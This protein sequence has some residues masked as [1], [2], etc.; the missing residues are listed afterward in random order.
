MKRNLWKLKNGSGEGKNLA[1]K[2][3]LNPI[4]ADI[5]LNRGVKE[6]EFHSF[7]F[8]SFDFLH[9]P[10]LLPDIKKAQKRIS[11]AVQN[12]EKVMVL[13]DYDVDG[14][15][16]LAIFNEFARK[17]PGV[18]SFYIPH[19]VKEGYGLSCRVIKQ[20]KKEK[21]DLIITFDC[22]VNSHKEVEHANSLG[23]DVVIVDHHLP[24]AKLPEAA[25]LV[26]PKRD[27][28][29]YPFSDLTAG[30]L[31]FKLL[32]VLEGKDCYHALDLVALSIVCDV[33]PLLGEN[34]ILLKEG[35][36]ILRKSKRTAIK[37]LCRAARVNQENLT[38]FHI[39][40]ILGPRV[41]A[42]GRIAHAEDAF[43]L[44][45]SENPEESYQMALKLN[46]YNDLRKGIERQIF[47][48]AEQKI[49]NCFAG[50]HALV[51]GKSGWHPGVLGVVAS[52][53]KDKYRRPSF[54]VSFDK[55][56]GKGSGRSVEGVH[57]INMLDKCSDFLTVYGGHKKAVGMELEEGKL[58]TFRESINL[59][60]QENIGPKGFLPVLDIDVKLNFCQI[61]TDFIN[62]LEMLYPYGEANPKPI[63]LAENIRKKKDIQ[64]GRLGYSVWL[65]DRN[66]VLEAVTYNKDLV[67]II[68][69]AKKL[70]IVFSLEKDNYHN[71]PRL[72]L[73][74]C[75]LA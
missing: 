39:G 18:F 19:R 57:L 50:E 22:G 16:S 41:N 47:K 15:V 69:Y 53:L 36:N 70:D 34:R 35:I 44:F 60:I 30:A 67:E 20:A 38:N 31:S 71:H 55:G 24:Q 27:D 3:G 25:A 75:R 63:F 58:N 48:E 54:V 4:I 52:R 61:D 51:V 65:T 14:I 37:A 42:S 13:G 72:A 26:N 74:D 8:P 17:F 9:S 59:A 68:R 23:I 11:Q 6:E 10:F 2:F 7:L 40:Y 21:K 43:K 62:Q 66:R 28:S 32:Q 64:K 46:K 12:K 49:D 73:R 56:V 33:A 1:K 45:L 29:K 5:I